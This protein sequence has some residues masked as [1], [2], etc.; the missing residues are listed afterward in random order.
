[1]PTAGFV[2]FATNSL[3]GVA[4]ARNH[5]ATEARGE[6]LAF[7]DDDDL[8]RTRQTH[9]AITCGARRPDAIGRIAAQLLIDDQT[10]SWAPSIRCHQS[11]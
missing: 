5:G 7:L 3:W 8:W 1:L 4:T 2:S 6:W 11:M 9:T 10:G